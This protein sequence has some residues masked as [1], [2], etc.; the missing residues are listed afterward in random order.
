MKVNGHKITIEAKIE[1]TDSYGNLKISKICKD[2]TLPSDCNMKTLK[3]KEESCA[4]IISA[5]KNPISQSNFVP[6]KVGI[7]LYLQIN[8][9]EGASSLR[10]ARSEFSLDTGRLESK[11]LF[12]S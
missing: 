10:R 3:T 2:V 4:L 12:A 6:I 11:S 1:A 9:V 8:G 5:E 7:F